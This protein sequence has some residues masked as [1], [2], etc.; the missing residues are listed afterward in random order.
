MS[1]PEDVMDEIVT[2]R[3]V[4]VFTRTVGRGIP[5]VVLHGGPG[6][7]HDYLRPQMDALAAKRQIRY[8]D[9][10]GGGRSRVDPATP[11]DWEQHVADLAALLEAWKLEQAALLGYSWGGLLALLFAT[12]HPEM[13][14]RLALVSPAPATARGRAEFERRFNERMQSPTLAAERNTLRASGLRESDPDAYR[15]KTF[16]LSVA[17]YFA[18]PI[19]TRN[20]TPFR[21]T[22]RTQAAVWQSLGDYDLRAQLSELSFP[23]LVLHGRH[24]P[25]PIE[26]ARE[27]TELL[28]GALVVFEDSGHVPYV[29]EFDRFVEVL[30]HFLPRTSDSDEPPKPF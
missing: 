2:V 8:Y 21:V 19:R 12:Q 18:D 26:T 27:T 23:T 24:D 6:A 28:R 4:P 25:I 30:D 22:G 20:L 29:E 1:H 13:V 5:V 11:V 14:E 7:H 3:G 15:Q 17:G 10:R 9:Q 16:E